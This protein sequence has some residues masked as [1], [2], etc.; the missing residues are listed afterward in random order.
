MWQ[1]LPETCIIRHPLLGR[2]E[3]PLI[4]LEVCESLLWRMV[5]DRDTRLCL[6]TERVC[7][8][9]GKE[10]LPPF[11][12]YATAAGSQTFRV[13]FLD[14][15]ERRVRLDMK[16]LSAEFRIDIIMN[17]PEPFWKRGVGCGNGI[18]RNIF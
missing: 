15:L 5:L 17:S 16:M 7:F 8:G 2:H 14:G 13:D 18:R 6:A 11:K 4:E 12:V 10:K 9:D 3:I 1:Q